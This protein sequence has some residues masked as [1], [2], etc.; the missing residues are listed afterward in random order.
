MVFVPVPAPRVREFVCSK[1]PKEWRCESSAA[2]AAAAAAVAA[3]AAAER[4]PEGG[5]ASRLRS[6]CV[7]GLHALSLRSEVGA[8]TGVKMGCRGTCCNVCARGGGSFHWG[9]LGQSVPYLTHPYGHAA[10][11]THARMHTQAPTPTHTPLHFPGIP[12]CT[13]DMCTGFLT[14][15]LLCR[16]DLLPRRR[17]RRPPRRQLLKGRAV[18][19]RLAGRGGGVAIGHANG[20]YEGGLHS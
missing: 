4:A 17:Q 15:H 10:T 9:W 3:A 12:V 19:P 20:L 11:Q 18:L 16:C 5:G 1:P 2:P 6:A 13:R 14:P 7:W 8:G